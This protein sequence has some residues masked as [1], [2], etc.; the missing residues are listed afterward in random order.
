VGV[1]LLGRSLV[2]ARERDGLPNPIGSHSWTDCWATTDLDELAGF[3]DGH[4]GLVVGADQEVERR[5]KSSKVGRDRE[6][7]C[8]IVE[9]RAGTGG[10]L[11]SCRRNHLRAKSLM[12]PMKKRFSSEPTS[13]SRAS[14]GQHHKPDVEKR[15][16]RE[17]ELV[18]AG[19]YHHSEPTVQTPAFDALI[20]PSDFIPAS[21]E[22]LEPDFLDRLEREQ[23][24]SPSVHGPA[25]ELAARYAELQAIAAHT[26]AVLAS[27]ELFQSA[28]LSLINSLNDATQRTVELE[29]GLRRLMVD[30]GVTR[31][32]TAHCPRSG[33]GAWPWTGCRGRHRQ[34]P[35]RFLA[36]VQA[37]SRQGQTFDLLRPLSSPECRTSAATTMPG[38]C[39]IT[40]WPF[41]LCLVSGAFWLGRPDPSNAGT[42]DE[43]ATL[44]KEAKQDIDRVKY[45]HAQ[46]K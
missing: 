13:T 10:P 24:A 33:R 36:L 20:N 32:W 9:R 16:R 31:R 18:H 5:G 14:G 29:V 27:N 17:S 23:H 15:S 7:R 34:A 6:T 40:T 38:S 35:A 43:C 41:D 25:Q 46:K 12:Q 30:L 39:T 44:R 3:G 2:L 19:G 42:R 22:Y 11:R 28:S 26:E 21:S 4:D 45:Y 8:K 37:L 1:E